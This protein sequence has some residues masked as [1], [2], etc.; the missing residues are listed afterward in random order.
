MEMTRSAI[1]R[2]LV[3]GLQ[4]LTPLSPLGEFCHPKIWEPSQLSEEASL[5]GSNP[6]LSRRPREGQGW[7]S[8]QGLWEVSRNQRN[9]CFPTRPLIKAV[10]V[11]SR[12]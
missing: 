8:L 10:I 9:Y 4:I 1:L 5:A 7:G 12:K 6:L 3:C 11:K 2:A